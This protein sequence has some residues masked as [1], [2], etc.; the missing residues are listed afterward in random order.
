MAYDKTIH[1]RRSIR[2]QGYNY[3][4]EDY[5]F[6]T[7]CTHERREVF[8]EIRDFRMERSEL[9]NFI[10]EEWRR[11]PERF[12]H[13]VLD[14]HVV[15]PNHFHFIVELTDES[16]EPLPLIIQHFKSYTGFHGQ[17]RYLEGRKLWHRNYYE[18]IIRNR[19]HLFKSRE[20]IENNPV[21]WH[22]DELNPLYR[23]GWA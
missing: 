6:V 3:A 5:Y 16:A 19:D 2:I 8:G 9:G 23:E 11:L 1:H 4:T 17:R 7:L 10:L 14:H 20:Y 22:L 13:V 12:E 18:T 15:M 21:N